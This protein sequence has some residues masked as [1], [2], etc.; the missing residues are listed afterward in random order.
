MLNLASGEGV[1]TAFQHLH[2]KH[3]LR[4]RESPR[5]PQILFQ[6]DINLKPAQWLSVSVLTGAP[7]LKD[8]A[9]TPGKRSNRVQIVALMFG[10]QCAD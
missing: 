10:H 2:H 6:E 8:P 5:A 3:A 1:K 4:T 9:R 7:K